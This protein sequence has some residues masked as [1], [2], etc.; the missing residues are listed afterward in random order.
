MD[1]ADE[2]FGSA[3]TAILIMLLVCVVLALALPTWATIAAARA[4]QARLWLVFGLTFVGVV[5]AE[6]FAIVTFMV[7]KDD[8]SSTWAIVLFGGIALAAFVGVA[9]QRAI[10]RA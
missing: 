5:S 6:I 7:I 1:G 4:H 2:A 3:I 8:T 10:G 9:K